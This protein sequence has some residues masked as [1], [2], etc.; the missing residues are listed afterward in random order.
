MPG[1]YCRTHV[2][3]HWTSTSKKRNWYTPMVLN[4]QNGDASLRYANYENLLFA[5]HIATKCTNTQIFKWKPAEK[6]EIILTTMTG[7]MA[8]QHILV[9]CE[10]PFVFLSFSRFLQ[11]HRTT[12]VRSPT[13]GR[14]W[15]K[16]R[17]SLFA[18]IVYSSLILKIYH[19]SIHQTSHNFA[20]HLSPGGCAR[21][22]FP[23][24]RHDFKEEEK[25][26]STKKSRHL[27]AFLDDS[28]ESW[29]KGCCQQSDVNSE[30]R[31]FCAW[32]ARY[33]FYLSPGLNL[34]IPLCAKC[35]KM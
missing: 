16:R 23:T 14:V 33:L 15:V 19:F 5:Q 11:Y 9:V 1:T 10:T 3:Q 2:A 8:M 20:W 22:A 18:A 35:D 12:Y 4:M 31:V 29:K 21:T 25:K 24:T 17:M 32:R 27:R 34:L 6:K 28:G 13:A 30:L 26:R 7:T